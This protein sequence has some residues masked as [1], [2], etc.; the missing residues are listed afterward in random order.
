M[1]Q[2]FFAHLVD[3]GYSCP[4]GILMFISVLILIQLHQFIFVIIQIQCLC[5]HKIVE[6]W[7]L[8]HE[9]EELPQ[10]SLPYCR[11]LI[12]FSHRA[13]GIFYGWILVDISAFLFLV[14]QI[15]CL[16]YHKIVGK[17]LWLHKYEY[18]IQYFAPIW[19]NMDI[20]VLH[21]IWYF[22][23]LILVQIHQFPYLVI[24]IQYLV[25]HKIVEKWI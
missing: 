3:N 5:N 4:I 1:L 14:N 19:W 6:T 12:I 25:D 8:L 11:V 16:G 7:I 13:L 24:Q 21:I 15:Q 2:Y 18:L 17:W 22:Y 9:Y 20:V 23:G 10:F